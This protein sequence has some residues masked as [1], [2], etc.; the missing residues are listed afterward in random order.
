L[1]E[2]MGEKFLTPLHLAAQASS[3]FAAKANALSAARCLLDCGA[4]LDVDIPGTG[5]PLCI[6]AES[7]NSQDVAVLLLRAGASIYCNKSQG[8]GLT[9]LHAAI[10]LPNLE[11]CREQQ[12][13]VIN[14]LLENCAGRFDDRVEILNSRDKD[15]N[16]VLHRAAAHGDL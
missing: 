9:V 15:G 1:D 11:L 3:Q 7:F 5:T 13:S 2:E 16:T 12:Y 6:A 10:E 4:G 14:F 8:D